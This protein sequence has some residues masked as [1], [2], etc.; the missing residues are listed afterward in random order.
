MSG[1]SGDPSGPDQHLNT[2]VQFHTAGVQYNLSPDWTLNANYSYSK[3][4]RDRSESTC[5][6][7]N[8]AGDCTD[9]RV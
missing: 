4:S 2:N 7:Q 3:S 5:Y 1:G 6:L 9:S 8:S